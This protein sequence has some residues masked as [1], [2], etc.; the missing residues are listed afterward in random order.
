MATKYDRIAADLRRK[1]QTSQL[2]PGERMP[3]ETVLKDEYGVSLLTMRRALD[4]LEMEGLIEKRH[5]H[6]NFVRAPRR[7]V[8]RTTDRYQWEKDRALL[9]EAER[10][11]TGAVERDTGLT[12]ED[13]VFEAHYD[14]IEADNDLA[15]AF[16]VAL[17][18]PL[19]RRAYHTRSRSEEATLTLSTSYLVRDRIAVNPDL[20]N[21]DNEPWPG[22]TPHQLYTVGIEIDRIIDKISARPPSAD[23]AEAL[24]IAAGIALIVLR[25]TSI[26]TAGDVVEVADVL[27]AGDRTELIYT[28]NLER[29]AT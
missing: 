28:T 2:G 29:Y 6:G 14:S 16:E 21:A 26:D 3:A 15:D 13:L 8:R 18:T 12:V 5:G 9:P 11:A 1:I 24:G 22:G 23:E 19:L 4:V 7:R 10:Q 27:M 25:K 17:G 20:L